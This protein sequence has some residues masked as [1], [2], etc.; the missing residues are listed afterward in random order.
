MKEYRLTSLP[1]LGQPFN[2]VVFRRMLSD[3]SHRHLTFVELVK[4]SGLRRQEVRAF[5]DTLDTLK[6]LEERECTRDFS[7]AVGL[8]EAFR[9][10]PDW[11]RRA[12]S[13]S[14]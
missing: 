11:L 7:P 5:L 1:E 10:T 3:L 6:L 8:M 2:K 12:L 13:L 4:Y 14:A 9:D